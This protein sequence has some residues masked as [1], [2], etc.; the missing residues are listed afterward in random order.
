M[1]WVRDRRIWKTNNRKF[2]STSKAVAHSLTLPSFSCKRT[3]RSAEFYVNPNT[4]QK[5]KAIF[6]L[7]F[8]VKYG[9]D[10]INSKKK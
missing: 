8:L 4:K 3:I 10:F 5:Y 1:R 2:K 7:D 6:G 9:I